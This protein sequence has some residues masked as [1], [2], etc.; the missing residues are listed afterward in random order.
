MGEMRSSPLRDIPKICKYY[1]GYEDYGKPIKKL[2]EGTYGRVELYSGGEY[3][4]PVAVKTSLLSKPLIGI[5][6]SCVRES[7]ILI[8]LHHPNIVRLLD[9]RIKKESGKKLPKEEQ[10]SRKVEILELIM[11]NRGTQLTE[12]TD[13][14]ELQIKRYIFQLLNAVNYLHSQGIYHRDIKPQNI[15]IEGDHLTLVDFGISRQST[16]GS[17]EYTGEMFTL[18][19]RP[20]E[21]LMNEKY[22]DGADIWTVGTVWLF[23]LLGKTPFL[24]NNDPSSPR[25]V[26]KNIE[27]IIGLKERKDF[28]PSLRGKISKK[29][30][31]LL[32]LLLA[33]LSQDRISPLQALEDSY[34][35]NIRG[36]RLREKILPT[37]G[38]NWQD[39]SCY[40]DSL[41]MVLFAS[42]TT[43]WLDN[44]LD[45][46]P[47]SIKYSL[48]CQQKSVVQT[49]EQIEMIV[50][51]VQKF[52]RAS[53][54]KI[55]KETQTCQLLRQLL[56]QCYPELKNKDRWVY[57]NSA[58]IYNLLT[59]LFP[60]L[61]I[62]YIQIARLYKDNY[63]SKSTSNFTTAS[64]TVKHFTEEESDI[65]NRKEDLVQVD[66]DSIDY[67]ILVFENTGKQLSSKELGKMEK[68]ILNKY[69]LIGIITLLENKEHNISYFLDHNN[70]WRYYDGMK[71]ETEIKIPQLGEKEIPLMFFYRNMQTSPIAIDYQYKLLTPKEGLDSRGQQVRKH[72]DL[73]DKKRILQTE[74][75]LLDCTEFNFYYKTFFLAVKLMDIFI[76]INPQLFGRGPRT[77]SLACLSLAIKFYETRTFSLEKLVN[78]SENITDEDKIYRMEK[79]IYSEL[80][81]NVNYSTLSII[82]IYIRVMINISIV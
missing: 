1:Q 57:Y 27:S 36:V 38:Y 21:V 29:G 42:K 71:K 15:L 51:E 28:F 4:I 64:F 82:I 70:Q 24:K 40:L 46:D 50:T 26:Y 3:G 44:I 25:A 67:P 60:V 16:S 43:F 77:V 31:K 35:N 19:Y 76:N 81:F 68:I 14:P 53:Y 23:L 5:F 54:L 32:N 72:S 56:W 30:Y 49:Q 17:L 69:E 48:I 10:T 63:S 78:L 47:Q 80:C 41:L 8:H 75:L 22:D 66:W 12:F 79:N 55:G 7:S 33:P 62:P 45:F 37:L 6:S 39:N 11:D 20:P 2:G 9:A 52:I 18:A 61:K 59:D 73:V 13:L 65:K 74:L 34:F 58:S